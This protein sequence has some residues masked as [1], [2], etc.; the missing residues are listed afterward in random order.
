M[1]K[2]EIGPQEVI[3]SRLWLHEILLYFMK[4]LIFNMKT[5]PNY[6][7]FLVPENRKNTRQLYKNNISNFG[8]A[9]LGTHQNNYLQLS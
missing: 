2:K 8:G 3:T 6:G 5:I 9:F 1:S 4:E 7:Y